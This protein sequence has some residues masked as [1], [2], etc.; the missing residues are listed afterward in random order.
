VAVIRIVIPRAEKLG[1]WPIVSST[2]LCAAAGMNSSLRRRCVA[3]AALLSLVIATATVAV[4]IAPCPAT[5]DQI[6]QLKA[7]A[8]AISQDL[9]EDQLQIDAYQQQYSVASAKV[10]ADARAIVQ[11][12]GRIAQDKRRLN[13][14]RRDVEE[15]A[16]LSYMNAGTNLS[17]S[18][19][20]LFTGNGE[21]AELTNE[22]SE[23]ATGNIDV[24]MDQ[25]H[26]AQ[27]ALGSEQQALQQQLNRDQLEQSQ[28]AADLTNAM[29][30]EQQMVSMQRQVTGQLAAAVAA[31]AA[32]QA[33][34]AA[35]AVAAAQR[36]A[37]TV[38]VT[39]ASSAQVVS[40]TPGLN[41]FLQ[42]VVQAESGGNYSAVSPTGQYMGA[43]QFSQA[44]W[45]MAAQAAGLSNLVG[46][47]PNLASPAEQD[48][49][50]IA[51][52]SLDGEQPWLGDRCTS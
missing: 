16:I 22:Y 33:A 43:F 46:V 37:V 34:A 4:V 21:A 14:D 41:T 35:A 9:V 32:A 5:A 20:V 10:A 8:G 44:T 38:S 6:A 25:L 50:A 24:A 23:L 48:A 15:Q 49:V 12:G 45:N 13:R 30:T 7:Q 39:A 40:A 1:F 27:R 3:L 42:C 17:G 2:C 19:A 47:A 52:Y 51:L 31:Q 36:A 28:E 29:D 11:M 18:D 26:I